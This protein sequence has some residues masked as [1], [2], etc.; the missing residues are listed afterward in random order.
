MNTDYADLAHASGPQDCTSCEVTQDKSA[1]WTPPMYFQHQNGTVEMVPNVGGMLAYYLMYLDNLEPFPE[2]FAMIAGNPQYR[3][4][5]GPFPD[6]PLS[7]WPTYPSDQFF[8]QQRAIG[9]NCLNYAATPE[10]S[11]YRHEFPAKDYMDANCL[12]GIRM[13]LAFPSCGN[14][15]AD[16]PDHRSHMQYPSL[17]KEGNCPDGFDHHYPLLFFETIYNTNQFAGVP[18]QFLVSTG[19]PVGPSYHGDFIMGWESADFLGQAINTCTSMTGEIQDC[20]LFTIQSDS[21]A[22]QC[23]FPMPGGLENDDLMGPRDGLPIDVPIQYGPEPATAYPVAGRGS[24]ATSVLPHTQKPSTFSNPTLT[25]SP[26]SPSKTAGVQG[27]I[28][29][30][31]NSDA[32]AIP[33]AVT[34]APAVSAAAEASHTYSTTYITKGYEVIEMIIEEVEMTVTATPSDGTS[35]RK[36]HLKKHQ[37]HH[38]HMH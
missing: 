12:D 2:G 6:T 24:V 3:N 25:Y 1:Y 23:T 11:L 4:F 21:T 27:G 16:S 14:G 20:P 30:A 29:V 36:R 13:E 34:S 38:H 15:A 7:S 37:H 28:I 33:A 26:A 5:T 35:D 19:D 9:F 32:A 18:G 22:A 8:L 31:F 17:V 10:A